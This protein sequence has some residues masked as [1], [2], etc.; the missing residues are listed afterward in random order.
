MPGTAAL[1]ILGGR[2][3]VFD[4]RPVGWAKMA[5]KGTLVAK[6]N[7]LRVVP[8]L[9]REARFNRLLHDG[10]LDAAYRYA[11]ILLG[12]RSDAEDA[13]SEAALSAWRH[14]D[15]LRDPARFDAWFGRILVNAC[16][17]LMRSRR[18][19]VLLDDEREL[20]EWSHPSTPDPAEGVAR[21]Q[22]I[23]SGLR[24]L[25]GAHREAVVLRYYLDLS[26][27]QIAARTGTNPGTV[28]SRLHHALRQLRAA[29]GL[30][31]DGRLQ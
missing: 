30:E 5:I 24:E 3:N 12:N 7:D 25:S 21:R 15:E 6:A 14:L 28:K 20:P 27:D 17:N 10:E 31:E 1:R 19:S 8:E 29:V 13:V 22:A 23:A 18:F 16:R 2:L 4:R 9:S 11:T 26:V